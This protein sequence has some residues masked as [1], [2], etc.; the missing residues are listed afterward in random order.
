MT[1]L[2][3]NGTL[4]T[5]SETFEADIL[6]EGE[7]IARIGLDL[8]PGAANVV[9]ASGKFV[10]PGGVDPHTHFD[11]PMFDTV[12]S[13]DHYTG[14]KAAAFGGTTTVIDF[15]VQEEKGF[16]YSMDRWMEKAQKAAIDYSFHMNLTRFDESVAKEIP[17]LREMGVTTLKV[18]TAYN[19]RLRLDDGS[20]FKALRIAGENGMLVMAHCE[21]GDVIDTLIPEAL[22]AGHTSPEWHARTRPAPGAVE[23]TLRMAAMSETAD[24]PVYIVH[25]NA[26][27]EVDMLKYARE[28]GVKVMGETCPQYLFFTVD[29]LRRPDG[30]KWV[31]SPPMR[32]EKDN[33]RLWEG[34]RAGILQT[35]GTDHC[36]FFFDGT[37]PILYEGQEVAIPG[38]ELGKDDFTKI[39]NGLPAVGDR[40]PILWTYGVRAGRISANQF[41]ALTAANPAK[42][43]GLY[44]RKG[45]LLPGSDADIVIWDAEKRVQYGAAHSHHRTDYNLFEGW[46]VVGMPEKV[47]L[48]GKLIVDGETWLG[49]RGQGQFLRRKPGEVL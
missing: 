37:K 47:F 44:P 41:V 35:V 6:I 27:G 9:D 38:K 4:I 22:A 7:K 13:D 14:H 28:R 30:A 49:K 43:F 46:E 36:P 24:A 1:T 34:L 40:L 8:E 45:A 23:A 32:T 21:N 16:Q 15:A 17:S 26:G 11:L 42:I 31:C 5:A 19:G 20:I 12:S 2:I 29:H 10:A 33:A 25:M 48:R 3:K 39:P 18:F